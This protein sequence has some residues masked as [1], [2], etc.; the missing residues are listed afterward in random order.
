MSATRAAPAIRTHH[1]TCTWG[2]SAAAIFLLICGCDSTAGSSK[3]VDRPIGPVIAAVLDAW[4][5]ADAHAI[6]AQYEAKGDFVSP[7]GTH[8]EGRREIQAF[9]RGA[10]AAG[11]AGSHATAEVAR[12]RHLSPNLA[13]VDG[14]WS[15]QPTTRSRIREAEAG[16]FFAVLERR[17]GRWRI[18]ALRE[19]S[20]AS[21]LRELEPTNIAPPRGR[22]PR[23]ANRVP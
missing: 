18:A 12:V 9:Y 8:A 22:P 11:Y 6:A 1:P 20:S 2:L 19:Q 14:S 3:T 10:F 7:D 5:R 4:D 15:I 17:H 16:L 13:L 23:A 21:A